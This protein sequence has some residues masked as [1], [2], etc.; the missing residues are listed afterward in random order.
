MISPN[1]ELVQ[2]FDK[3]GTY[4]SNKALSRHERIQLVID[5]ISGMTDSYAL[6]LHKILLGMKLP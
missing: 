2:K 1:F 3:D 5:Y 4:C 6:N